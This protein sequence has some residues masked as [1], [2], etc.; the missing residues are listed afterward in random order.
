MRT[1]CIIFLVIWGLSFALRLSAQIKFKRMNVAEFRQA[2][3]QEDIQLIDVR[4]EKEYNQGHIEN[5]I[6]MDVLLPSFKKDLVKL[7][8]NKPIYLYCKSGR[9]SITALR[10]LQ[11]NGFEN[12]CDLKGGF[13]A[14][15]KE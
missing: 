1:I 10:I 3:Q 15:E 12:A 9:R 13:L 6:H 7:Y 14:W 4:T 2:I 11:K 8:K 5:A